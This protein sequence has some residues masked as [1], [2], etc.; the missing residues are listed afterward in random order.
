MVEEIT[1]SACD[2]PRIFADKMAAAVLVV[3]KSHALIFYL[4]CVD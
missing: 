4:V 2:C 1:G 3:V